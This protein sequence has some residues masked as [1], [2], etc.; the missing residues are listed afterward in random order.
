MLINGGAAVSVLAFIG[1]LVSQG[2]VGVP[3]LR[4]VASSLMWFA[5]GVVAAVG[6][7]GF[8]YLSNYAATVFYNA[9]KFS[10]DEPHVTNDPTKNAW[11]T[12]GVV[13][14]VV[15][16]AAGL[17][18]LVLFIVGMIDVKRSIGNLPERLK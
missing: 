14:Q 16:V 9:R 18:A 6:S 10:Y 13:A 17:V 8:A 11:F 3:Q 7:M 12:S 4:D 15:A 5:W 2:K 1:G